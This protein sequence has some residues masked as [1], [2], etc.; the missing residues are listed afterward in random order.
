MEHRAHDGFEDRAP[1]VFEPD[2]LLAS[3]Y[4][5]RI[6]RRAAVDGERRLIVAVLEDAVHMYLK[7]AAARIEVHRALFREAEEW[8]EDGDTQWFL[9]FE[10]VCAVLDLDADYLRRG[11][12]AA[13]R[14]A[15]QPEPEERTAP[16]DAG[17]VVDE[18]EEG[19]V[20]DGEEPVHVAKAS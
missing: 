17:Y 19:F 2:T 11:L 10:N 5:D 9:S 3:Q 12:R 20:C 8:I 13:K 18:G 14:R 16:D 7:H 4:F 15:Q 6:R 1:G